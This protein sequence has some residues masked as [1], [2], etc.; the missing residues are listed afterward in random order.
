VP[1]ASFLVPRSAFAPAS[2]NFQL[3]SNSLVRIIARRRDW[4]GSC[5]SFRA[6]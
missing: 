2:Q 6:A 3:R 1:H 5:P 4:N